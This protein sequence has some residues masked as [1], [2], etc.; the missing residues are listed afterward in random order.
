MH[1]RCTD[2]G[3]LRKP[4]TDG[5][6]ILQILEGQHART[7]HGWSKPSKETMRGR[8]ADTENHQRKRCTDDA[9]ILKNGRDAN[10][11]ANANVLLYKLQP[12]ARRQ[13]V[14]LHRI[15]WGGSSLIAPLLYF[16]EARRLTNAPL[17]TVVFSLKARAAT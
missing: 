11:N 14:G 15:C 6:L 3:N 8:C 16:V 5:A 1:G 4:C 9:R 12:G 10:D 17:H 2:T 7:M 13:L